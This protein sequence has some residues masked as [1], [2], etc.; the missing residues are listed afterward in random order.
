MEGGRVHARVCERLRVKLPGL[1]GSALR[2]LPRRVECHALDPSLFRA[3]APSFWS[4]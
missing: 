1:L 3:A 2:P 4:K